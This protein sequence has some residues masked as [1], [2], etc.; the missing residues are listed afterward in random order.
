MKKIIALSILMLLQSLSVLYAEMPTNNAKQ[1]VQ[2]RG[3]IVWLKRPVFNFN[4]AELGNQNRELAFKLYVL[5][6]GEIKKAELVK[7]SGITQ[8]DQRVERS[9]LRAK[10]KPYIENG[11]VYPFVAVQPFSLTT[12]QEKQRPW[13]KKLLFIQ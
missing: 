11:V 10:F 8:I 5:T 4:N 7:S 1:E 12:T 9:L 2:T 6:T 3:E 13:W